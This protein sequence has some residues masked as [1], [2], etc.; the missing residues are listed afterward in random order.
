ME[1]TRRTFGLI[2]GTFYFAG[3]LL[4]G[5]DALQMPGGSVP[6]EMLALH[7]FPLSAA[8]Q[9]APQTAAS[10]F[11]GLSHAAGA[12]GA[13]AALYLPALLVCTLALCRAVGG[14]S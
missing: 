12:V 1:M 3:G 8:A 4:V 9:L 6:A 5:S 13:C 11:H 2:A 14:R 7:V 10:A